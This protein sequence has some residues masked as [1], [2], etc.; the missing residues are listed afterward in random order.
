MDN[1]NYTNENNNSYNNSYQE[2]DNKVYNDNINIS[3]DFENLKI[4]DNI[5]CLNE[6]R[7]IEI[8]N[9]LD[10]EIK[11]MRSKY[12]L[13]LPNDVKPISR[14]DS[15]NNSK[16]IDETYQY[17]NRIENNT[18]LNKENELL[19]D[20]ICVNV[21][22]NQNESR[23]NSIANNKYCMYNYNTANYLDRVTNIVDYN[24]KKEQDNYDNKN[25]E[26]NN[27][28][29][30]LYTSFGVKETN[31]NNKDYN[32]N[33]DYINIR[34]DE[35]QFSKPDKNTNMIDNINYNNNNVLINK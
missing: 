18:N 21:E 22:D 7:K 12:F 3:G 16:F 10:E 11:E 35:N 20:N 4:Q 27:Y 26:N 8:L 28:N 5:D 31:K 6:S 1:I 19:E 2:N 23:K 30:N 34:K 33:L 29:Y 15:T 9:N 32:S 25:I 24:K 17:N 14:I 13:K